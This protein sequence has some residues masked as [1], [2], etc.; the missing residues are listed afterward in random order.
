[1]KN[2]DIKELKSENFHYEYKKAKG[3]FPK[4]F[5]ETYSAFANSDG[6]YIYL[7]IE[8]V[9]KRQYQVANL[10]SEEINNLKTILF[11]LVNDKRKVSINLITDNDVE[12]IFIDNSPVLKIRV[13]RCPV[14][15]RPV[16]I[17]ANVYQGV[18]RR[19]NEGDYHCSVE[20]INEMIRDS[21]SQALDLQILENHDISS[22]DKESIEK[23]KN[24]FAGFHPNH[25]F[26]KESTERFLEFIGAARLNQNKEYRVTK[27]GLLMFGFSYRIVYD[28]PEFFL[29]YQEINSKEKR[30]V[31][32]LESTSGDWSGNLFTYFEKVSYKLSDKVKK[33]FELNGLYRNDDNNM[34]KAIREALCNTLCNADYHLGG[35]IVIKNFTDYI[36]FKN[37]G[38]L[39]MD[40]EQM[41]RGGT[42]L[43]RNKTLLK[44]FNL[45]NIGER[46][47]SGVPL[48][49]LA[50]KENH[51]P[52]PLIKEAFNPTTT[53]L[54][55]YLKNT[56]NNE[57]LTKLE[58]D[59]IQYL[60]ESGPSS[61]KN[62]S[63][64]LGK[65]ITTIKLS[66]YSLMK[67]S[68]ISSSGTVKDKKY[69]V[70]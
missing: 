58:S 53:S 65:N 41:Q 8:E 20:D 44:M 62:I 23:Y 70:K 46:S 69:F 49:F 2:I 4:S 22:L 29:D 36:E 10:T 42:S 50:S 32:R 25:P 38:C 37:P 43:P 6:G 11:D 15:L 30:W 47:G 3:G 56:N 45:I 1:M 12:E 5:W 26:L 52:H 21:S 13:K 63:E 31:D 60:N 9:K 33:P 64:R 24:I 28:F 59:I 34:F 39:M 66:L 7:G 55:L 19:N 67:I 18:F 48:L 51:L 57:S 35:G 54:T 61:A 17:N 16:Y 68:L 40:V 14:E 27:A